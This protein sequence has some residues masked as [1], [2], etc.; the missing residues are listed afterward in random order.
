MSWGVRVPVLAAL[1][2]AAGALSFG[3]GQEATVTQAPSGPAVGTR[4]TAPSATREST[5]PVPI[6]TA[7][8][9]YPTSPPT[10]PAP[11][12]PNWCSTFLRISGRW[13][14]KAPC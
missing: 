9:V 2:L 7:N 1:L 5:R 6:S 14:A 12:V 10:V 8:P 11:T 4:E 3:C 13:T